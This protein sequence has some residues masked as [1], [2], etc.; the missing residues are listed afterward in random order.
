MSRL[1]LHAS[2]VRRERGYGFD[3]WV[4]NEDEGGNESVG[5]PVDFTF[6]PLK[7]GQR[8]PEEPTFFFRDV[9]WN[10]MEESL[11]HSL[12]MCGHYRP[13]GDL[14]GRLDAKDDHLQDM[15]KIVNRSLEHILQPEKPHEIM[16]DNSSAVGGMTRETR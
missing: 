14:R 12:Q 11:K 3:V 13:E 10:T 5:R 6:D 2:L 9:D 1:K 8:L 15:R 7:E 4:I 16:L